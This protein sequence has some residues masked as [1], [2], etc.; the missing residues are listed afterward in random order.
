MGDSRLAEKVY[1]AYATFFDQAEAERRWNPYRDVPW[2]EINREVSDDLI[3]VAETFC[4]VESY[5]PDY[6]AKGINLV[7]KSFGQ[8]WFAANWAYEESKH[9]IALQEYLVRS[10]RRTEEQMFDLQ[11][12]LKELEWKLPFETARQM[13][14]YGCFQEMATFYIYVRQEARAQTEGDGALRT[15]FR[16]NARDEIAHTHFYEDVVKLLL[17]EDRAG[18]LADIALVTRGFRMPAA[19]LVPEYDER[20]AV[21]REAGIDRDTFL[22]KVYFP[23]LKYLGVTRRELVEAAEADRKP[24]TAQPYRTGEIETWRTTTLGS[25]R[26]G[27]T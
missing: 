14:I 2:G 4:A 5:L 7:R 22:Q 18:T 21:M 19:D 26:R 12:R 15:I 25:P 11:D 9:S 8:A 3:L 13:T 16:L 17:E 1:R 24:R 27:K 23:V 10:G 20:V 6:V